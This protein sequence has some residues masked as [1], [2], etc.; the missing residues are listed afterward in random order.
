MG[1]GFATDV[2]IREIIIK[3]YCQGQTVRIMAN[4]LDVPKSTVGDI[5]KK[6]AETGELKVKGKSPGR[7]RIVTQR[8]QRNLIKICKKNRRNTLRDITAQWNDESG[9]NLSRECCRKWI[10]K[11]GLSFYKVQK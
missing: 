1:R 10:H 2:K 8:S 9:T 6:Y 3:K 7:P 5:I 4:D 11:S